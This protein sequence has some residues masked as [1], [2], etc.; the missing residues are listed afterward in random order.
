MKQV[1]SRAF[2][3]PDFFA[4]FLH[5]SPKR[6]FIFTQRYI[7]ENKAPILQWYIICDIQSSVK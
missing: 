4:G 2:S 7:P 5:V 1:A 3:I 6:R